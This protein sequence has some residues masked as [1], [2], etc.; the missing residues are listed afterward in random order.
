MATSSS[1][2]FSQPS[3]DSSLIP[4][5][6][7]T[8]GYLGI[9]L[10]TPLDRIP[11]LLFQQ[12]LEEEG[13]AIYT[14][15]DDSLQVGS[16]TVS[17]IQYWFK[18][19]A[20]HDIMLGFED[21]ANGERLRNTFYRVYGRGWGA[22]TLVVWKGRYSE[23]TYSGKTAKGDGGWLSISAI[24]PEG[25]EGMPERIHLDDIAGMTRKHIEVILGEPNRVE[26][27]RPS[28]TPCQDE[29]CEKLYYQG[30]RYEVVFIG[31][32][33]DWITIYQ[34]SAYVLDDSVIECL[35]LPKTPPTF[36]NPDMVIRWE[37]I[38][39]LREISFFSNGAGRVA[40]IYIKCVTR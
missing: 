32:V 18:N 11:G 19:N 25:K 13:I 1:P 7:Q 39:G 33:A 5:V 30:D 14:R 27:V 21:I 40:S 31:G 36:S 12:D 28:N 35:G 16:A 38:M 10:G 8:F 23:I 24:Q 29:P 26:M 34:T 3:L 9:K 20:L 6:D 2:D 4:A 17:H 15:P 22:D 37:N